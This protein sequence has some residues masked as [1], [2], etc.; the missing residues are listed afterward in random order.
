[1]NTSCPAVRQAAA[2]GFNQRYAR[3]R[4]EQRIESFRYPVSGG[5]RIGAAAQL[6]QR[7]ARPETLRW[8]HA[9]K[10]LQQCPTNRSCCLPW[11]TFLLPSRPP[12]IK[13]NVAPL[14]R[15]DRRTALR[16]VHI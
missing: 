5:E 15:A 4:I 1:I 2:K 6:R 13:K 10:H 3:L 7:T 9:G 12:W 8:R 16:A 11:G 14:E